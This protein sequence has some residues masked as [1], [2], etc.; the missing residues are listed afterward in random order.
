MYTHKH[1]EYTLVN[2]QKTKKMIIPK[3]KKTYTSAEVKGFYRQL[4]PTEHSQTQMSELSETCIKVK[5]I[6]N[7]KSNL[8]VDLFILKYLL[9]PLIGPMKKK[10]YIYICT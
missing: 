9:V 1:T 7:L 8:L 4:A 5:R 6:N 2:I 3:K 10:R